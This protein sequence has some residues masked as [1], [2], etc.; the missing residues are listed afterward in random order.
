MKT[1]SASVSTAPVRAPKAAALF[2]QLDDATLIKLVL[3][4]VEEFDIALPACRRPGGQGVNPAQTTT[5]LAYCY[6]RGIYSSEEIEA[7]LP[8]DAAISYI[9]AGTKPDWHLLRRYRRDNSMLI[10]GTLTRLMELAAWQAGVL[11]TAELPEAWRDS[12]RA[13]ALEVLRASIQTDS[14]VMDQ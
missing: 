11:Y 5:L 7:R 1:L 3:Q 9:S 13:Q 14:M 12:F 8:Y 4:A 10:L 6:A 2:A